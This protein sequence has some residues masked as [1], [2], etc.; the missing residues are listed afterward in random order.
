MRCVKCVIFE[1][2][3]NF[4]SSSLS[5]DVCMYVCI[6]VSHYQGFLR[7]IKNSSDK[8]GCVFDRAIE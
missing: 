3:V 8:V 5:R 4:N 7:K 2:G 1:R 6:R